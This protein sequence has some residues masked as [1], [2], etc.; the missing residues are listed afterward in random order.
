VS[1]PALKEL[2]LE[3]HER[4]I[5]TELNV[6]FGVRVDPLVHGPSDMFIAFL[7][8][9]GSVARSFGSAW[10]RTISA[11]PVEKLHL[12]VRERGVTA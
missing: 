2:H 7:V 6:P 4:G 10:P 3:V 8:W 9:L 11:S 1:K 12:K 5:Y